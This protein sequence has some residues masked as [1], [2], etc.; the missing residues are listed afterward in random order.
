MLDGRNKDY[1]I[2]TR[3]L[4]MLEKSDKFLLLLE[5]QSSNGNGFQQYVSIDFENLSLQADCWAMNTKEVKLFL[6]Y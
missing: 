4:S 2:N 6:A 3:D 5:K 1:F